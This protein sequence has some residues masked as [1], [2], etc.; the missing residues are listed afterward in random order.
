MPKLPIINY[1]TLA[2]KL[3]KAGFQYVRTKKHQVYC[4]LEKNLTI[5]IP[6]NHRGD[7]PKGTLRAIIHQM[8]M[9]VDDFSKL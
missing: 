9:S 5:P 6:K 8:E 1:K 2:R 7:I 4:H 3:E